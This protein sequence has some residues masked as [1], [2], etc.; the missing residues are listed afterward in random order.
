MSKRSSV[1]RRSKLD[2]KMEKKLQKPEPRN[3]RNGQQQFLKEISLFDEEE[4][5]EIE[6][7]R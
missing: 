1:T 5:V 3:K 2:R 4:S 6:K 7:K